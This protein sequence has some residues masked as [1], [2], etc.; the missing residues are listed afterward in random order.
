MSY[1]MVQAI[2]YVKHCRHYPSFAEIGQPFAPAC[3]QVDPFGASVFVA[4]KSGLNTKFLW[5]VLVIL[6]LIYINHPGQRKHIT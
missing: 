4:V 1:G 5:Q 6:A 2:I 3:G